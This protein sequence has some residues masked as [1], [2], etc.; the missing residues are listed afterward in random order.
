MELLKVE[1]KFVKTLYK[2]GNKEVKDL[3]MDNFGNEMFL[4]KITERVTSF[5]DAC[6]ESGFTP[7]E[8]YSSSDSKDEKAYKK[9]K[10]IASLLREEWVPDWNDGGQRKWFPVFKYS[11]G[12]GFDFSG[13]GY[14]CAGTGSAVGSRLCFPTEELADY[15]GKQFID[16]HRELIT[17]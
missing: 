16:I 4:T 17:L 10:L 2:K 6:E 9:L 11:S 13:S 14:V 5:E 3:L 7:V 15:F 8:I 1:K 12:V